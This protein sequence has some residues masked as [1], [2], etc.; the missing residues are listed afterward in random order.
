MSMRLSK[1]QSDFRVRM[2]HVMS[3][4]PELL[5]LEVVG[6]C[7][8]ME[9]STLS[10]LLCSFDRLDD[11]DFGA[12]CSGLYSWLSLLFGHTML[13]DNEKQNAK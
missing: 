13:P 10:D 1:W 8:E 2:V 5:E 12:V 9:H 7:S 4:E 3:G 6:R 11:F